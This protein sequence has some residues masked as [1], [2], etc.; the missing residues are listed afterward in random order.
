[1]TDVN[2]RSIDLRE[3]FLGLQDQLLSSLQASRDLLKHPTAKGDVSELKWLEMLSDHLPSRYQAS[4]AFVIDADGSLSHQIDLVIHDRQYSPLLLK[5]DPALYV[6]A[7]SVYAV[8]EVKQALSARTI[9]YAGDKAASVRRLRRTS[10]PIPH[11]GGTFEP[12]DPFGVLA[13]ILCLESEWNSPL[14][15]NL[16]DNLA[17]LS[18]DERLDL[19]CIGRSGAFDA[20]YDDASSPNIACSE[21]DTALVFFFLRLLQ[22]LQSLGTVPA[23]DLDEYGRSLS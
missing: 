9:S 18:D 3:L 23:I 8:F 2:S 10:A 4:K 6:P 16:Q 22:R 13:G 19:G 21:V 7:E 17:K 15:A 1:M 12:R 5:Q 20:S 11:A 14:C